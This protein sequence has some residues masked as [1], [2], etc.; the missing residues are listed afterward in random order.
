MIKIIPVL[1]IFFLFSACENPINF[2][3]DVRVETDEEDY[4]FPATATVT[5]SNESENPVD[6]RLCDDN[7]YF[8]IQRQVGVEWNT[9]F[10]PACPDVDMFETFSVGE[11]RSFPV[12]L[13]VLEDEEE[14]A[15]TYRI[16]TIIYP[17]GERIVRLP[18]AMRLSNTFLIN[19]SQ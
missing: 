19:V 8:E 12:D 4:T 15:G 16:K 7:P 1:T 9:V 6:I 3:W 17:D 18:E 5:I 13:T 2:V 10:I 11:S 14:I